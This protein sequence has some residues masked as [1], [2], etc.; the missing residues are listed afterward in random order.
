MKQD[1]FSILIKKILKFFHIKINPKTENLLIQI[2]KFGIVGGIA[3]IIDFAAI[4]ILREY[5]NLPIIISNT[6]AFCI[7]N[8]YNYYASTKWVFVVDKNKDKKKT[9]ITFFIFSVIGLILN[10][11]IMLIAVNKFKIYYMIGKVIATCF[12]MIFN[13]ITRK[14]FLE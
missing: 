2:F 12:V 1:K 14:L 13:F 10:D 8:Q 5:I 11:T 3:T 6:L 4:F 9:F 7:A